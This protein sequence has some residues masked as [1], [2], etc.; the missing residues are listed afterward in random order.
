MHW[1]EAKAARF[2][3]AAL[4]VVGG[5]LRWLVGGA[6]VKAYTGAQA[7][8]QMD[9]VWDPY[10]FPNIEL[11]CHGKKQ[12]KKSGGGGSGSGERKKH[13]GPVL[14]V[15]CDASRWNDDDSD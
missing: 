11:C 15:R 10:G 2:A 5:G 14:S 12:Q 9:P 1:L 13:H 4:V 3:A 8:A 7:E 6:P